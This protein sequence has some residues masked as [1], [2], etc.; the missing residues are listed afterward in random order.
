MNRPQVKMRVYGTL[1][2][3]CWVDT[4]VTAF[5]TIKS[6]MGYSVKFGKG[7][8]TKLTSYVLL[9]GNLDGINSGRSCYATG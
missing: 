3:A 6:H 7:K 9:N 8:F 5:C 4:C 2:F 1:I